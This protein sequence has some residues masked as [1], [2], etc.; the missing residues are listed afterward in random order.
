MECLEQAKKPVELMTNRVKRIYDSFTD[1]EISAKIS[2]KVYPDLD[3]WDGK[4]TII[5][6]TIENLRKSLPDHTGDWYFT[7]D[8]PT[9][10][11][12]RALNNAFINYFEEKEGRSY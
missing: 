11:G 2:Q 10:G 4:L 9:P 7:G 1:D 12:F 3:F 8:F 6:Q 5:Y